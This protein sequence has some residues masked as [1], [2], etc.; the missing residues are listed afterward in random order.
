MAKK[1]DS[2]AVPAPASAASE[3]RGF[4]LTDWAG[5]KNY[6]C[7]GCKYKT[8]DLEK[9]EAHVAARHGSDTTAAD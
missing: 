7:L 5:H 9:I 1:S 2:S 4:N 6:E 3:K 8:L